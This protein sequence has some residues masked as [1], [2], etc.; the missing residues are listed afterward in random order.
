MIRVRVFVLLSHVPK[1]TGRLDVGLHKVS[2]SYYH[3]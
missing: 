3:Y 1:H 2:Y